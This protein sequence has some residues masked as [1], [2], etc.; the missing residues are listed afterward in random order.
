MV[1]SIVWWINGQDGRDSRM[2]MSNNIVERKK[3]IY[4][5]S[6]G[7]L[8]FF[9]CVLGARL[10]EL[11]DGWL[12]ICCGCGWVLLLALLFV[13]FEFVAVVLSLSLLVLLCW[14]L[15]GLLLVGF[16]AVG[17]HVVSIIKGG[18]SWVS[19]TT[20]WL[21]MYFDYL[22]TSTTNYTTLRYLK[23]SQK[24]GL[25]H[26]RVKIFKKRDRPLSLITPHI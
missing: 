12:T 2:I 20:T 8:G 17:V 25:T 21:P 9:G 22:R 3:R 1:G 5:T 26:Q 6:R 10:H 11:G 18:K 4:L 15:L 13:W 23:A 24:D 7:R 14:L 19:V 16:V